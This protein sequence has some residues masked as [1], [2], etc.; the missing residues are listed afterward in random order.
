MVGINAVAINPISQS[1]YIDHLAPISVLMDIPFL[2]HDEQQEKDALARYPELKTLFLP[3]QDFNPE[4]LIANFDATFLSDQWDRKTFREKFAPLEK[5]YGKVLRNVH[6]PHGFSD[7]GFYLRGCAFED[8]CLIYG[9]NML[10]LLKEWGVL[11]ELKQH[12]I[13]GN[14]RLTYYKKHQAFFDEMMEREILSQFPKKK[15]VI[16]YAPTCADL[17]DSTSFFE[18]SKPLLDKLP[19]DYNM[20]V[21]LHPRLEIEEP[22]QFYHTLGHYSHREDIVFLKD[23]SLIYPLLAVSD[24][25]IGDMSSIGYDFL[26]FNRPMFFLNQQRRDPLAD[27]GLYLFRAGT[28]ISPENYSKVYA[29]I[30]EALGRDAQFSDVRREVYA[31]TFGK[32]RPFDEI[33]A[34]IIRE[35]QI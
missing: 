29:T 19:E 31:Y 16:L 18:A 9:Q 26:S 17:E 3:F 35:I 10:D 23:F 7:K 11:N 33:R 6:C 20:I 15:K 13:T 21:K 32:E 2:F 24:L 27:R 4:Y 5:E 30:E 14:Y 12:V 25:Y 28:V 8:I 22:A 34:D 1:Q